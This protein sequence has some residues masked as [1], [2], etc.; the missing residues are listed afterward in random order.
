MNMNIRHF[1]LIF[2]VPEYGDMVSVQNVWVIVFKAAATRLIFA[3]ILH[4]ISS[5]DGWKRVDQ[6]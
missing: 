6:L 4:A 5:F 1:L 2:V 3:A